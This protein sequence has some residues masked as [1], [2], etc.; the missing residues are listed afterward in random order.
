[1]VTAV[2]FLEPSSIATQLSPILSALD[3]PICTSI[4]SSVF[5]PWW[6]DAQV[7]SSFATS[8][9]EFDSRIS[10]FLKWGAPADLHCNFDHSSLRYIGPTICNLMVHLKS[11]VGPCI[12]AAEVTP[13][14]RLCSSQCTAFVTSFEAQLY[15]PQMCSPTD[16]YIINKRRRDALKLYREHC[17]NPTFVGT[18]DDSTS[19]I[20]C[21]DELYSNCGFT[22]IDAKQR[23][24]STLQSSP[25]DPCCISRPMRIM[26]H[27]FKASSLPTG[28]SLTVGSPV[29]T[30]SPTASPLTAPL[31]IVLP[32]NNPIPGSPQNG[33]PAPPPQSPSIPEGSPL[34]PPDSEPSSSS[35]PTVVGQGLPRTPQRPNSFPATPGDRSPAPPRSTLD[36]PQSH[37]T[38]ASS[39][40]AD[41]S[42]CK[43]IGAN[44]ES[45]VGLIFGGLV[46]VSILLTG[47][48][49]FLQ[50]TQPIQ[51]RPKK[52]ESAKSDGLSNGDP[53]PRSPGTQSI[54]DQSKIDTVLFNILSRQVQR[55]ANKEGTNSESVEIVSGSHIE[56]LPEPTSIT[57]PAPIFLS[58]YRQSHTEIVLNNHIRRSLRWIKSMASLSSFASMRDPTIDTS[59]TCSLPDSIMSTDSVMPNDSAS[60]GGFGSAK[61]RDLDRSR[62]SRHL[63]TPPFLG[64]SHSGS[65]HIMAR[66]KVPVGVIFAR[67]MHAS[68]ILASLPD[69]QSPFDS[70]PIAAAA[71]DSNTFGS[72]LAEAMAESV[73]SGDMAAASTRAAFPLALLD[74]LPPPLS[75]LHV[76]L[77]E[78]ILE[79]SASIVS[80]QT[81]LLPSARKMLSQGQTV[82]VC[83]SPT[84]LGHPTYIRLGMGDQVVVHEPLDSGDAYGE[85][86][87]TGM[88]GL[89]PMHAVSPMA[90]P[91]VGSGV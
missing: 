23:Y 18:N 19:S 83:I 10:T 66:G 28:P 88:H 57:A 26:P 50:N 67:E 31:P 4:T 38:T 80:A 72:P 47:F 15:N 25:M 8:L 89:F 59:E 70:S 43:I 17:H 48:G 2:P 71:A 22:T 46:I 7:S 49:M 27:I 60:N 33:A 1:M 90:W 86:L 29:V 65:L 85:N 9:Y 42:W 55:R 74:D 32:I 21:I 52:L 30:D 40:Q 78:P 3:S 76:G 79:E 12:S 39:D 20:M 45:A 58:V 81:S 69:T 54:L 24:C 44:C 91:D 37:G 51:W 87:G 68:T 34:D 63:S 16:D 11:V 77:Q 73:L 14:Q 35:P 64:G 75:A 84:P 61:E 62:G 5:C 41:S 36:T 82:F 6:P 56:Q 13:E 53:I